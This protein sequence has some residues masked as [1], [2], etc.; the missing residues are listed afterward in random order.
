MAILSSARVLKTS[1]FRQSHANIYNLINNRSNVPDPNDTSGG[2]K[3]VHVRDPRIRN[4]EFAGFP[5]VVVSSTS[6]KQSGLNLSQSNSS[7][8]YD[9]VISVVSQDKESDS[10]G[11]AEGAEQCDIISEG[12][13]KTVNA[14]R[15]TLRNYGMAHFELTDS[16]FD[17]DSFD[18][19]TLFTREF[20][21]TFS[22]VQ[23]VK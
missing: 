10:K 5:F 1:L 6:I 22:A 17:V 7:I 2:R 20:V 18:E 15:Y 12:V 3:F 9:I 14:N 11:N 19:K 21:C 13:L 4:R 16:D 8:T 23:N